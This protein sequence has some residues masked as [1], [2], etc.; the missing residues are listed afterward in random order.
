MKL[1]EEFKLY[2]DLWDDEDT[3]VGGIDH[4][5][6]D[7]CS[8]WLKVDNS[9]KKIEA[10]GVSKNQAFKSIMSFILGLTQEEIDNLCINWVY[11]YH[12][13][14]D[15]EG[16]PIFQLNSLLEFCELEEC[17]T[18]NYDRRFFEQNR[19]CQNWDKVDNRIVTALLTALDLPLWGKYTI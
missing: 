16:D 4:A 14:G 15:A 11:D 5:M 19:Y 17:S 9:T 3:E 8:Y 10:S 1:H 13:P 18:D 7:T 6:S 2:E 12:K